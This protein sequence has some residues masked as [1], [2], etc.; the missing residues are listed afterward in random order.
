MFIFKR[1]WSWK[2]R[3]SHQPVLKSF[4]SE[5]NCPVLLLPATSHQQLDQMGSLL[6]PTIL[7]TALMSFC[8][9]VWGKLL[10]PPVYEIYDGLFFKTT[11]FSWQPCRWLYRSSS[12]CDSLTLEAQPH[13]TPTLGV[14]LQ[15]HRI[16]FYSGISFW[17][18]TVV[19]NQMKNESTVVQS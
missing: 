16:Y 5:L 13:I 2:K 8:V 18:S 15:H 1:K 11:Y 10:F 7:F 4:V 17:F 12:F 9:K 6:K 14:H 19:L 3:T